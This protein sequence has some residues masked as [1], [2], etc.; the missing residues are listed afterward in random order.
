MEGE[1]Y[2]THSQDLEKD[3][4]ADNAPS[5]MSTPGTASYEEPRT[6]K[7]LTVIGMLIILSGIGWAI[8][9]WP[10]E[11]V[12][13][14]RQHYFALIIGLMVSISSVFVFGFSKIIDLLARIE[15]HQRLGA[16]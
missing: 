6:I 3:T 8:L 15:W 7:L 10:E 14:G 5:G 16:K 4:L 12:G 13:S 11:S 1:K 9:L 2:M